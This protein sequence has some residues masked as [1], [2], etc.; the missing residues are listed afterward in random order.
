MS[1]H[2]K[3]VLQKTSAIYILFPSLFFAVGWLRFPYSTITL[4]IVSGLIMTLGIGLARSLREWLSQ[5][6]LQPPVWKPFL[7]AGLVLTLWLSLSGTG[8]VG[9]QNDDY[10]ASNA[11]LKD[12]IEQEWPLRAEIEGESIPIAYY[13]GYFLPAAGVGKLLGWNAA[14]AFLYFW[15]LLGLALAFAWFARIGRAA[16]ANRGRKA[17]LF[18]LFFCLAGGLDA[19]GYYLLN[20]HPFRLRNHVE[21]WT[22]FFQYSSMTTLLFWVPQHAIAAWISAGVLVDSILEPGEVQT[23]GIT[24]AAS[25]IWSP[26]GILGTAP[27]LAVFF[28][29]YLFSPGGRARFFRAETFFFNL[30]ALWLGGIFILYIQANQFKFP[31]GFIWDSVR[32]RYRATMGQS[33][34]TFGLVEFGMLAALVLLFLGAGIFLRARQPDGAGLPF[35]RQWQGAL[36][37]DFQIQPAQLAIFLIALVVLGLLPMFRMG[38]YNDLV[39]RGSIPSLFIF[40]AFVGHVVFETS[41]ELRRKLIGLYVVLLLVLALSFFP[42][43]AEIAR[44]VKNYHIGAPEYASVQSTASSPHDL[45][46]RSGDEEA[47]FYRWVGK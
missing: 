34:L 20:T 18:A 27:Y 14:N 5:R 7:V 44:S 45:L 10:P 47:L 46:Q 43:V 21:W 23:V 24:L 42:A 19:L 33:I 8:G 22:D 29:R 1:L 3:Q 30:M 37:R 11:L 41:A 9:F 31:V 15:T 32:Y 36:W 35:W 28:V 39:M 6:P 40:F 17:L 13:M 26:F 12:L 4:V 2:Q 38:K 16:L 25:I